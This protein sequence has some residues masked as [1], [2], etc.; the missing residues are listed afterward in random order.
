MP[1]AMSPGRDFA[2]GAIS[3]I[4]TALVGMA[5]PPVLLYLLLTGA[6][7][8]NFACDAPFVFFAFVRSNADGP[9][10]DD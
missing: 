7:A 3:G 2:A 10:R 9:C 8:E 1:L 6:G 4:A 5:G